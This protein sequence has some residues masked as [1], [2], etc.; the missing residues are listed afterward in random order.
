MTDHARRRQQMREY[1]LR[2]RARLKQQGRCRGCRGP[3]GETS[4]VR[5][6]VCRK[7]RAVDMKEQRELAHQAE[8]DARKAEWLAKRK[9]S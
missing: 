1:N 2:Y 9:A 8:K 5:C 3:L 6:A 4:Y 7:E